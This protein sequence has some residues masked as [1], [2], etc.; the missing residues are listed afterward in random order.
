RL[1]LDE[2]GIAGPADLDTAEEIGLRPR[3]AVEPR[4]VELRTLAEDLGVGMEARAGSAP[5]VHFAETFEPGLRYAARETLAPE[6]AAARHLDLAEVGQ[7]VDHRHADAVQAARGLVDL[8]IELSAG[9]QR[10]HDDFER[11]LVL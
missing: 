2:R 7:G 10:G 4:R 3:H 11:R 9:V 5:V 1:V 8:G 6:L